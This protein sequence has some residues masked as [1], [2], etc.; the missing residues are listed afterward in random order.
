MPVLSGC[1]ELWCVVSSDSDV[2]FEAGD[3]FEFLAQ[4]FGHDLLDGW[5]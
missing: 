5:W 4:R 2:D 3:L 1:V